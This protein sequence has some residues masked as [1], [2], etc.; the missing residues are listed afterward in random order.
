MGKDTTGGRSSCG[1]VET[2]EVSRT[3]AFEGGACG[4]EGNKHEEVSSVKDK[5]P[6]K[7]AEVA[8]GTNNKP[9]REFAE[10]ISVGTIEHLEL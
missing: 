2:I 5:S 9:V 4:G 6:G 3:G 8:A 10:F 1:L 7:C